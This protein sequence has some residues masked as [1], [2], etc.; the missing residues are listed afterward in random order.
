MYII[1]EKV[2]FRAKNI[3]KD[4][5]HFV[6]I[7]GTIY[8]EGIT[9]LYIYAPTNRASKCMKQKLLEPEG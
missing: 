9:I 3:V 1:T 8:Q 7:M 2:D 4:E 5:D 6:M